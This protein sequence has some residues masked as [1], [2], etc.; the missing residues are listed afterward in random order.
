L[1]LSVAADTD[2]ID[3]AMLDASPSPLHCPLA[4]ALHPDLPIAAAHTE[5]W[6][7]A[8]GLLPLA[9]PRL[10]TFTSGRF[11][12]LA[13]RCYA[14]GTREELALASDWIAYLFF[15]DDLCDGSEFDATREAELH[16]LEERMLAALRHG[17]TSVGPRDGGGPLVRASLDLHRRL[18]ARLAPA[19]LDRLADD[20][21]LYVEGVRWERS[22]RAAGE[23]PDLATYRH[24]RPMISAVAACVDLAVAFA[25]PHA[26]DLG[27]APMLQAL[28]RMANNHISWV[29][30]VFSFAR[31]HR[32]GN[33]SN[34]V[35]VL[36]REHD[37]GLDRARAAAIDMCN[38]ELA[39]FTATA[40]R[41]GTDAAIVPY[42]DALSRWIRGNLDWHGE[43]GRYRG[44][45]DL[46]DARLLAVAAVH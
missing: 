33:D 16:H 25:A 9:S 32:H 1:N 15:Y 23:A 2:A 40:R 46:S 44:T 3:T 18:V 30:D 10:A 41:V 11:S 19:W 5:R 8:Q 37:L 36:S 22:L 24:L 31:E 20:L 45:E 13:A 26:P 39:A 17:D 38:A 43:S 12:Q 4:P 42:V 34:L 35:L 27:R 6:I 7:V 29:N 14:H 21:R 28:A